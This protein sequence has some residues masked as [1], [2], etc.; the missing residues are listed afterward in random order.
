MPTLPIVTF[1]LDDRLFGVPLE[2]VLRVEG[3]ARITPV[4]GAPETLLGV[5][6]YHG[7]ILPVFDMRRWTG[8]SPR[9]LQP[10]DQFLLV[11]ARGSTLVLPVDLVEGVRLPERVA[12][13][14]SV[15][16]VLPGVGGMVASSDGTLILSDPERLLT[17]DDLARLRLALEATSP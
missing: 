9:P 14:G 2:T 5:L 3:A 1:R 7:E 13:P 8:A 17:E 16:G 4:P 6:N 11:R 15:A 10:S 12:P